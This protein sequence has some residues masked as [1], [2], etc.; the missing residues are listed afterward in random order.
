[1]EQFDWPEVAKIAGALLT[2]LLG[3]IGALLG[4]LLYKQKGAKDVM[5]CELKKMDRSLETRLIEE[6]VDRK[7]STKLFYAT[8]EQHRIESREDIEK[9]YEKLDKQSGEIAANFKEVCS[10]RQEGCSTFVH[11]EIAHQKEQIGQVCSKIDKVSEDRN[12][13]WIEQRKLNIQLLSKTNHINGI[14]N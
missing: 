13:K 8:V 11:A 7:K 9:I 5:L 2:L 4:V 6:V 3:T 14:G 12:T 1:M 10:S